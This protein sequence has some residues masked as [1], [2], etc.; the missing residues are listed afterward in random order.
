MN[1]GQIA[2]LTIARAVTESIVS[3]YDARRFCTMLDL[4]WEQVTALFV[5]MRAQPVFDRWSPSQPQLSATSKA[6]RSAARPS[7]A[8][9]RATI[10]SR[11]TK[12]YQDKNPVPGV[13]RRCNSCQQILTLN[14]FDV[15]VQA[16][17]QLRSMCRP[18]FARY[19]RARYLSTR[20]T[21]LIERLGVRLEVDET[22]AVVG[23]ICACCDAEI[24]PGES[25]LVEAD[26]TITQGAVAHVWCAA[27]QARSTPTR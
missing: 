23:A 25:V 16:T 13:L 14:E 1:S 2:Q 10:A 21:A 18:C 26:L 11:R 19:Q 8:K 5:D 15:K 22:S 24:Q 3:P 20:V 9:E 4:D 6:P 12:R 17:G 27:A 7:T